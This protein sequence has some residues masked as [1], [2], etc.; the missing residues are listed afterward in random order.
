MMATCT[1]G[2]LVVSRA[3]PSFSVMEIM[4]VSAM[5]KFAPLMPMSARAVHLPQHLAGD[6]GQ[7]LGVAGGRGAEFLLEERADFPARQ[8]H[9]GE[10]TKWYGP[11]PANS[12]MYSPRSLST[13]S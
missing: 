8:V 3:L 5:A 6:H 7:F 10:D 9:R 2:R 12:T 1:L 4:P 13:T 11:P